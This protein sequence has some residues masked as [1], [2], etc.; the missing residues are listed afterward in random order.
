L[1]LEDIFVLPEFRR[2][3]VGLDLFLRCVAEARKRGC[4]RMEWTVLDWNINAIRF[5]RKLGA[6]QLTQWLPFRL[7]RGQFSGILSTSRFRKR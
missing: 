7:G 1:Y 2:R 6:R 4:G 5:Y 3:R